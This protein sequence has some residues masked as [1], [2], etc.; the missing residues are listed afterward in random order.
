[1]ASRACGGPGYRL[2]SMGF[3]Q[4]HAFDNRIAIVRIDDVWDPLANERLRFGVELEI[5]YQRDLLD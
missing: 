1:M 5:R 3:L 2:P 4:F